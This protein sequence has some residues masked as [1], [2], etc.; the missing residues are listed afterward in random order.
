[1]YIHTHMYVISA[2]V[3]VNIL[4]TVDMSRLHYP[5]CREKPQSSF[6]SGRY[7][8]LTAVS[9]E[10]LEDK[11]Q[12]L[13]LDSPAWEEQALQYLARKDWGATPK[14]LKGPKRQL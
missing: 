4:S 12:T 3:F 11:Y 14:S 10:G 6:V 9:R 7:V 8:R 13:D 5:R 2:Y 1:M